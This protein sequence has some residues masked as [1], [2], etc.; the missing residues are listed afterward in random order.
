VFSVLVL[1]LVFRP[2]GLMGDSVGQKA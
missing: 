2:T 1:V